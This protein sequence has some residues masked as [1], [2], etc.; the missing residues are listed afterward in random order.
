[1]NP[2]NREYTVA[3][4]TTGQCRNDRRTSSVKNKV[5]HVIA[6]ALVTV[7]A[8]AHAALPFE[9]DFST[10]LLRDDAVNQTTADWNTTSQ[11]LLLPM[12]A[13]L[14]GTVLDSDTPVEVITGSR[15]TRSLALADL[16][17]DGDLDL[18]EGTTSDV[19][20]QLNDGA[21]F[22]ARSYTNP[23][24]NIRVVAA[25]DV[26]RDG[27]I[28]FVAGR[29]PGRLRIYINDGT[30]TGFDIQDV[31]SSDSQTN[32]VALADIN[33]DGFLDVVAANLAFQ[34]NKLYLNTGNP[35]QPFGPNG[36]PGID[37]GNNVRESSRGVTAGDLDNDGD[38]DL[39][40]SNED[41][42]NPNDGGRPQRNR[43]FMNELLQGTPNSFVSAEIEIDGSDDVG[44]TMG[45]EIG[46]VD[47]DGYLDFVVA[48]F[49]DGQASK[50]YLNN[51]SGAVNS[52]PFT[53]AGVDFAVTGVGG[54]PSEDRTISLA[55]VDQDGDLD[56][57]AINSDQ[58]ARNR[59]YLNDG[60]GSFT[61]FAE[62][63]PVGQLPLVLENPSDVGP[64]SIAQVAGDID[65]DGDIDWIVGNQR[66]PSTASGPLE[67][68]LYR[69]TGV[70][71]VTT[72]LQL[73]A[74]AT[75][76]P[77][78]N[79][80]TVTSVK[81]S[82][83]PDTSMAGVQFHNDIEYWITGDGGLS[84][85]LIEAD[86]RPVSINTGADIRWRANL[87]SR[88]PL[89][90]AGLDLSVL[91][92][93]E[94]ASGPVVGT[95]IA[96]LSVN[97]GDDTTNL[98]ILSDFS[99]SD[100]DAVYY[101]VSG[102]PVG[103]GLAIDP[104]AGSISGTPTN[105]DSNASPIIVTVFATDGS[106]SATDEFELTVVNANDPPVFT[107]TPPALDA[108]QDLEYSYSVTADDPDAGD[109]ALL[110][111]T[112][113]TKP[114]WLNLTVNG[115]AAETLSGT[116]TSADVGD[117][118]VSLLVTDF[119]GLTA[120]QDFTVTVTNVDDAPAFTS[121]PVTDATQDTLYTYDV[122]ADDPDAGQTALLEHYRN[123]RAGLAVVVK[124]WWR[125]G[126]LERHADQ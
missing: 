112:A 83:A 84:W 66:G 60:F 119:E 9:E 97:E 20:V 5:A 40:F 73:S 30:G 65:N 54:T 120:T 63:G 17:G 47:G 122:T 81:L 89:T 109:P 92:V 94:N 18:I 59:V 75:S 11:M 101:A 98:P 79:S 87:V 118:P 32:D 3:S 43:V 82:P 57:Y 50:V 78:D 104:I 121:T 58:G 16:D 100:G 85:S 62:I 19:G 70:D 96:D 45:G 14:T 91:R 108:T 90:A 68:V 72:A 8:F 88:S 21:N 46:D 117:H 37:I 67:N 34:E 125:L 76:L 56:I 29:V 99:D 124:R 111:I 2:E 102:L 48:N 123:E 55:D 23:A 4:G 6:A 86:G 93:S 7:S 52:N 22:G 114:D 49:F 41:A 28:D 44:F 95:P 27:D 1:M 126:D 39:V 38:I 25:G 53:D 31:A 12:S 69:N 10:V 42:P 35:V 77:I 116:P 36:L 110:S 80:G 15:L 74:R 51:G 103:T 64:V 106:L 61:T 115:G 107:S 105:E 113:T 33:G 26:D 24:V 13:S 71:D